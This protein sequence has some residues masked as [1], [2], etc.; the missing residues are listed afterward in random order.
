MLE[1]RIIECGG[2]ERLRIEKA[3]GPA[4]FPCLRLTADADRGGWVVEVEVGPEGGKGDT[5]QQYAHW[6]KVAFI[7]PKIAASRQPPVDDL[8]PVTVDVGEPYKVTLIPQVAKLKK[9]PKPRGIDFPAWCKRFAE[10][11]RAGTREMG[12]HA[13]IYLDGPKGSEW[14]LVEYEY[15]FDAEWVAAY[16]GRVGCGIPRPEGEW[17]GGGTGVNVKRIIGVMILV[18]VF[19]ALFS[20]ELATI[21]WTRAVLSFVCAAVIATLIFVAGFL[22]QAPR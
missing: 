3:F 19:G 17:E 1:E 18:M 11:V 15:H 8:S 4:D 14:L 7:P 5:S 22:I 21:G 10:G 2:H 9:Y 6:R 12:N 20:A 16:R 13:V